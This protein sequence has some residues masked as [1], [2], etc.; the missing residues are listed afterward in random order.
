MS[1]K[2][3][4]LTLRE[5]QTACLVALRH[6]KSSTSKIAIEA[7]LDIKKTAAALRTLA[8]LGLAER[9]GTRTWR[10]TARGATCR[11]ETVPDRPRPT[12]VP[13]P[14]GQRLLDMLD[15]PMSGSVI[16][17][18]LRVNLFLGRCSDEVPTR[19][20]RVRMPI[21][22][23]RAPLAPTPTPRRR[24][25]TWKPATRIAAGSFRS[26]SSAI[27]YAPAI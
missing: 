9:D 24:A 3:R 8:Q 4:S 16:A 5:S 17:E 22:V 12:Q 26:H 1:R 25:L 14:S 23:R 21:S 19:S 18:R 13:G 2:G 6:R 11:F 15:R 20:R 27:G 10:T 7:N